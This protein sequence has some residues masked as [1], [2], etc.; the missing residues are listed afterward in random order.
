MRR[1]VRAVFGGLSKVLRTVPQRN[2]RSFDSLR[3]LRM[4]V[5]FNRTFFN[6]HIFSTTFLDRALSGL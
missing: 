3:E 6:A 4:A 1:R 5:F 2:R